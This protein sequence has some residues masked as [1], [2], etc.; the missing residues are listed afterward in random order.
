MGCVSERLCTP[1]LMACSSR[2]LITSRT[3]ESPQ[4]VSLA[5]LCP[6]AEET[7]GRPPSLLRRTSPQRSSSASVET[8]SPQTLAAATLSVDSPP[9][10]TVSSRW[11]EESN[12]SI[13]AAK[14]ASGEELDA[15]PTPEPSIIS[16]TMPESAQ[17]MA[18]RNAAGPAPRMTTSQDSKAIESVQQS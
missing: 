18:A 5:T 9:S 17:A 12:S 2:T 11:A 16:G 7:C 8:L 4:P 1:R 14:P 6:G 15:E 13:E 3:V 10:V